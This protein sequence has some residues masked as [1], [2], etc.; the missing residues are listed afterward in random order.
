M[1]C[2]LTLKQT[3]GSISL[4]DSDSGYFLLNSWQAYKLKSFSVSHWSAKIPQHTSLSCRNWFNY[5]LKHNA[6]HPF[7]HYKF[8]CIYICCDCIYFRHAK[9]FS[10][11]P[12]L[13]MLPSLS[14]MN[15][16]Y[17]F[18]NLCYFMVLFWW[19]ESMEVILLFV[20]VCIMPHFRLILLPS[21]S[22]NSQP[23]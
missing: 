20:S 2:R 18:D 21:W 16:R 3:H 23:L 14:S 12:V 5:T 8:D 17:I 6:R 7:S 10:V 22:L 1:L 19:A 4:L 13:L 11:Q 9:S 15:M